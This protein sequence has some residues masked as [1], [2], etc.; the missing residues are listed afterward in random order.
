[1]NSTSS[2]LLNFL[3]ELELKLE[4]LEAVSKKLWGGGAIPPD[5][6]DTASSHSNFNYN[7]INKIKIHVKIGVTKSAERSAVGKSRS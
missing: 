3:M 5:F 6:S 4:W 7:S 2:Q 1:M